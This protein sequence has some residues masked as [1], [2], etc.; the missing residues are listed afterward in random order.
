M[1]I[2]INTGCGTDAQAM[3]LVRVLHERNC[4]GVKTRLALYELADG[5]HVYGV[6]RNGAAVMRGT[7]A[8][9]KS[10]YGNWRKL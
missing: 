7:K 4:S 8:E 10:F 3:V 1:S 2:G 9:A 6:D 5:S